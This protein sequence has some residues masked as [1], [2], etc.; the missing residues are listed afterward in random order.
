MKR[1]CSEE[2]KRKISIA[3]RG[4]VRSKETKKKMSIAH[5]RHK[6]DCLCCTCKSKRGV[7]REVSPKH[8]EDC[9]CC[10]CKG[11]RG[12]TKGINA[13]RYGTH[14]SEETREKLSR[15][16][17]GHV[18]SKE[19]REKIS[20]T[21]KRLWQNPNFVAKMMRAQHVCPNKSEKY[22]FAL[23]QAYFPN[24][25][26]YVGDGQ[27]E[28]YNIFGGKTPDFIHANLSK[29]IEM[30][31]D[32]W[33]SK[34]KTGRTKIEEEQ[35]RINYFAKYGYQTLVIWEYELEDSEV[36]IEKIKRFLRN[37]DLEEY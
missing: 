26:K 24:Q 9:S 23:L 7:I 6:K 28:D 34:K 4:R 16:S 27:N 32:W 37:M 5:M 36:I 21:H 17:K 10:I 12:E 14:I 1:K 30:N 11:K 18:T 3:N 29:I 13:P 8:K 2:T 22:L 33:H 19:T 35:Q 15:A 25:W 20:K 31:G